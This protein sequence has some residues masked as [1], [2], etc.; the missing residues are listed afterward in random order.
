MP[1]I[2]P[3]DETLIDKRIRNHFTELM[4]EWYL[5]VRDEAE[6]LARV[7]VSENPHLDWRRVADKATDAALTKAK[8]EHRVTPA[9]ETG[10]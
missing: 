8:I 2:K 3:L 1:R 5:P 7:I 6:R 4:E 9:L 10:D